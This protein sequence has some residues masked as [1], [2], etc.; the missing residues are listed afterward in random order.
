M[1]TTLTGTKPKDTYDSLIKVGDNGPI[2]GTAKYLSDGL[3]N[4]LP[5]SVSTSNV[6]IGT[7]NPTNKLVVAGNIEQGS[8][9]NVVFTNNIQVVSSSA[10]MSLNA[11][12]GSVVITAGSSERAR[13]TADGLTFNGDTAAA[14]ALDDYEE[15]TWTPAYA[16]SGGGSAIHDIQLGTYTKIGNVVTCTFRIAGNKNTL[17]GNISVTGLPFSTAIINGIPLQALRRFATDFVASGYVSGT[18]LELYK[19]NSSSAGATSVTD[20]DLQAITS[21]NDLRGAFSY[22]V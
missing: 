1:G 10:N 2:S 17:S 13:F 12:S 14:N 20:T 16:A 5:I 19:N 6:G 8:T 3:G 7:S 22:L 4:D 18:S 9:A 15:G 21:Y 11:S